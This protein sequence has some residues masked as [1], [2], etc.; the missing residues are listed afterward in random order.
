MFIILLAYKLFICYV[1]QRIIEL[2]LLESKWVS[3]DHWHIVKGKNQDTGKAVNSNGMFY[4][5]FRCR[6]PWVGQRFSACLWPRA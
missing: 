2:T 5:K 3:R 6:D 1:K 4:L